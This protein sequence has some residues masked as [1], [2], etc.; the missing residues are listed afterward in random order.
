MKII[1]EQ[2]SHATEEMENAARILFPKYKESKN[3]FFEMLIEDF[4][5]LLTDGVNIHCSLFYN[6]DGTIAN[7]CKLISGKVNP[8]LDGVYYVDCERIERDESGDIIQRVWVAF[9]G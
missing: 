4:P 6:G 2:T 9:G 5:I 8:E 3:D 7:G 1:F